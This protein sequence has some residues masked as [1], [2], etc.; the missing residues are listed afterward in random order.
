MLR[1]A[2]SNKHCT[3]LRN[4]PTTAAGLDVTPNFLKLPGES[5][6]SAPEL[7]LWGSTATYFLQ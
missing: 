2:K 7:N 4:Y 3:A 1:P 6:M 5:E